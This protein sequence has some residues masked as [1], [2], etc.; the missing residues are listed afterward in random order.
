MSEQQIQQGGDTEIN[1]LPAATV[2]AELENTTNENGSQQTDSNQAI[3]EQRETPIEPD[4][5]IE[6][7]ADNISDT[8]EKIKI[9]DKE[10]TIAEIEALAA[11]EEQAKAEAIKLEAEKPPLR[12]IQEIETDAQKVVQ[13]L[14][15]D[16]SL[17]D[18]KYLALAET[19]LIN[20]VNEVGEIEQTYADFTPQQA[21]EHALKTGNWEYFYSCL[22]PQQ[23]IEFNKERGELQNGYS[24]VLEKLLAEQENVNKAEA[25]KADEALWNGYIEKNANLSAG[26][27]EIIN[28]IQTRFSFDEQGVNDF[29]KVFKQALKTDSVAQQI[30]ESNNTAKD[31]IMSTSG[32]GSQIS[33]SDESI[34]NTWGAIIKKMDS[35]PQW[36][37]RNERKIIE[38]RNQGLIKN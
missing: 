11:K 21:Y 20:K 30:T 19:P 15:S 34:P 7:E 27:K 4:S 22:T 29:L 36:W 33:K 23:A 25:L 16:F 3:E 12:T 1:T 37:K 35:N 13:S 28:Y 32:G 24:G 38:M 10:Y 6:K 14:Q 9:K 8:V 26:E 31:L 5:T 2:N 17:L 18:K